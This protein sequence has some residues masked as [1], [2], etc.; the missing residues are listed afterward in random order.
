MAVKRPFA[1]RLLGNR[2]AF[3]LLL[4]VVVVAVMSLLSPY[5]LSVDGLLG[6]TRFGAVLAL[7]AIGQSLII[8]AGGAGI[9]ISVGS[10]ISLSG[11]LFG[12]MVK[13]GLSLWVAVPACVVSGALLGAV[14]GV[15]VA[16]WGLPPMIGT[17]STMWAYGA[18]ALVLTGGVPLS[19]FP[20]AF[21]FLGQG[22]IGAVPAQ[23]LL[24]VLPA[25]AF[26]LFLLRRTAFGRSVYLVGVNDE[27]ARFAGI[28]PRA[29]RFTL[30][31]LNGALA[32]CGALI[33]SSW[34]MA[35][36]ADAGS[37]MELQAITVAVLGGIDIFGGSGSLLGTLL[38]VMIVTMVQT[39]LQ[40]A[41]I[42]AIWQLALL[43]A[44]L[45]GAVALNQS[46]LRERVRR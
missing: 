2:V 8:L 25:Y 16:L 15:T 21:G 24:F 4:M 19:G 33:L 39:G 41:N 10:I 11:V 35:A 27:A 45:L 44:I 13:A 28:S 9:D 7:V 38:A 22:R 43:G 20:E 6:M 5:F 34:L 32:G 12:L 36:R 18:V 46:V 17:F 40:L 26:F 29:V 31:T 23:T 14:N 1:R 42:N 30:Y 3:L 37:G